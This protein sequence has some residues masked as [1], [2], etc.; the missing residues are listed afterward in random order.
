MSEI[1]RDFVSEE[2]REY[3]F[4]LGRLVASSL[5]GFIS[6]AVMASIIWA[7]AFSYLSNQ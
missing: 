6:G 4:K 3:K 1:F 7:M 2:N 5:T